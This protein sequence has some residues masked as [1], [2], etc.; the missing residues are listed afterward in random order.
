LTLTGALSVPNG[1]AAAPSISFGDY[2]LYLDGGSLEVAVA[3]EGSK[4]FGVSEALVSVYGALSVAGATTS[5]GLTNSGAGIFPTVAQAITA[6]GS[7]INAT[8]TYQ[9]LDPNGNYTLT[10]NPSIANG[11]TGQVLILGVGAAEANTVT[12]TDGLG[13][14][15]TLG[16]A[17]TLGA[18]DVLVMLYDGTDW[19][20]VAYMNN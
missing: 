9:L 11:A 14:Q 6:V 4:T 19:N 20:E 8:K 18:A 16:V 12:L 17:V 13:M 5:A 15:F 2:G 7:V 1:S 3:W 10:S